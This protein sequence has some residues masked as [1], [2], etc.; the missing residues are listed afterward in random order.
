MGRLITRAAAVVAASAAV[1][2]LGVSAADAA[3]QAPHPART[4]SPAAR[5][6]AVPG[7]KLWVQRYNGPGNGTDAAHS[8]AVSPDGATVFVTGQSPGATPGSGQDDYLTAAYNAATGARLWTARYDGPGTDQAAAVAVSPDGG[9]VFVTGTTWGG[10]GLGGNYAT[11]AYRASDGAQL[12]VARYKNP[13]NDGDN[14]AALSVARNGTAVFVTGTSWVGSGSGIA[15]VAYRASDGAQLWVKNW[16]PPGWCCNYYSR[17]IMSPGGNRVF[18][19]ALVQ[20]DTSASEYGTVAYNA[21]T[22]AR[23]WARR[24]A[25][26]GASSIAVSPDL[27]TV[28]VTGES[29]FRYGTLA[30][31]ARTGSLIWA[32]FYG[33]LPRGAAAASVAVSPGGTVVVTGGSGDGYATVAYSPGGAQ[34][35]ARR[36]D[37]PGGNPTLGNVDDF[38]QAVAA[39]GNGR[40]YV[41]GI[42]WGGSA[43]G[44]DYATIAYNIRTGAQLWV[45]RYNGPANGYDNPS[46]LAARG[47]RV[48]VT[49]SSPGTTSG[50]DYATIAYNG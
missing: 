36:Y 28:Y 20:S 16:S 35:W 27:A 9:T 7:A 25:G 3:A 2:A 4:S 26:K 49:G 10:P 30:Y 5:Q 8:V 45:R 41:T 33:S 31:S 17:A 39:P 37:G 11:V 43:T 6:M 23:L 38:G 22:G 46:S 47:G 50:S 42:S 48:F 34:L 29:H 44:D 24:Y 12:W 21:T 13:A 32:R 15:T 14:A 40:V 1:G 19:T 18:V